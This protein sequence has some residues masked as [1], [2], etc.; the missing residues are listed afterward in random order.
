[1]KQMKL[2]ALLTMLTVLLLNSCRKGEKDVNGR[3]TEVNNPATKSII[4]GQPISITNRPYQ[5]AVFVDGQFHGGGVL[6]NNEWV[7]TAAHVVTQGGTTNAYA[8]NRVT[9]RSGSSNVNN[10]NVSNVSTII[11]NDPSFLNDGIFK[12]NDMALVRLSTPLGVSAGQFPIIYST[13]DDVVAVNDIASVSGWGSTNYYGGSKPADLQVTNVKVNSL[14]DPSLIYTVSPGAAQQESCDGDSGGPLVKYYPGLGDVLIGIV[15]AGNCLNSTAIFARVSY[16]SDW[17]RDH[18]GILHIG[19]KKEFCNSADYYI[20]NLPSGATVNWSVNLTNYASLTTNGNVA[21]LT[22]LIP[23][24]NVVYLNAVINASSLGTIQ[25]APYGITNRNNLDQGQSP[26]YAIVGAS[27][28]APCFYNYDNGGDAS[29]VLTDEV[30]PGLYETTITVVSPNVTNTDIVV[31]SKY[32][33]TA[34]VY[35]SKINDTQFK[36]GMK[37]STTNAMFQITYSNPCGNSVS[38]TVYVRAPYGA[39]YIF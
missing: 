27:G 14:N 1:M 26:C 13:S 8:T 4:G 17:I 19:G 6:L 16:F 10:G 23:S 11:R 5:V 30:M 20:R 24:V 37:G 12:H 7:L 34:N 38:N 29:I 39:P 18:T 31:Q 15:N 28:P 2:L 36:I 32:P 35:V 25:A 22:S 21:T 3:D 9:I 33:S